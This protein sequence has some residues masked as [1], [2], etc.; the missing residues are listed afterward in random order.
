MFFNSNL[1]SDNLVKLL[2]LPLLIVRFTNYIVKETVDHD[3]DDNGDDD[4]DD[5]NDVSKAGDDNECANDYDNYDSEGVGTENVSCIENLS[6][7]GAGKP[8]T[9][10]RGSAP[11]VVQRGF[12]QSPAEKEFW[13]FKGI[14]KPL[15]ASKHKKCNEL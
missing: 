6:G 13:L 8:L 3:K 2:L 14:W 9:G 7:H 11:L 10:C 15:R 12:V 5:E 4:D 1:F